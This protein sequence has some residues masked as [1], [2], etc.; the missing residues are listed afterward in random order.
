MRRISAYVLLG[1]GVFLLAVAVLA[2]FYV[3]PN[4]QKAPLDAFSQTPSDGTAATLFNAATLTIENNVPLTS[5]RTTR[6]DVEAG[7]DDVAVYDSF[8]TVQTPDNTSISL[9]QERFA[10]DRTSS[11]MVDCCDATEGGKPITDF[12]GI[13]PLKF[14]FN[15]QQQTYQYFDATLAKALPMDFEAED[16]IE[17]LTVYRFVQRIDPQQYTTLAVPGSLVGTTDASVEAGRFYANTRTLWIEPTTGIVIRG[18]EEQKQTLRVPGS[19]TDA[20]TLLDAT[21]AFTD[22]YVA[23]TVADAEDSVSLLN[24][25]GTTLPIGAAVLG[26][27]CIGGAFLLGRRA[28]DSPGSGD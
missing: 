1:L 20:L 27:L 2:R 15:T 22:E 23:E 4:A 13:F 10:F 12:S 24:A 18:Q 3:Y 19:D 8:S 9:N 28:T 11:Q 26:L 6:G 5:L 25:I 16:E 17:G 7:S 21:L 14:P